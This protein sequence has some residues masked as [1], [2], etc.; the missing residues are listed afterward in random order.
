[1]K[2]LRRAAIS[3]PAARS[4]GSTT[5]GAMTWFF[6]WSA[7]GLAHVLSGMLST[8]TNLPPGLSDANTCAS[9]SW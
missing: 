9:I 3:K 2:S 7:R 1:M 8:I 6:A 5:S 4:S